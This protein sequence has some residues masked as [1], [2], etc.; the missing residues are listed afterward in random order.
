M[1]LNLT[2]QSVK[3]YWDMEVKDP[4]QKCIGTY[5]PANMVVPS[6]HSWCLTCIESHLYLH[7]YTVK[8]SF[9][10]V[11]WVHSESNAPILL[12]WPTVLEVDD[13]DMAV[14]VEP[15]HQ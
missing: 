15:S 8:W 2:H 4:I 1:N 3:T 9:L 5:I 12:C 13:G 11:I 7:R 14:D 6:F 10:I